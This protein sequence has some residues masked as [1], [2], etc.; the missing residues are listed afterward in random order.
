MAGV[1]TSHHIKFVE[2]KLRSAVEELLFEL[3]RVTIGRQNSLSRILSSGEWQD[4]F[5]LSQRHAIIGVTFAGVRKLQ[6]NGQ[7]IP[8]DLYWQW[9]GLSSH[10]QQCNEVMNAHCVEACNRLQQTGFKTC[11]LKGQ[12]VAQ[13]YGSDLSMLR[14]SGDI[15]LWVDGGIKRAM[16]WAKENYGDVAFEYINAHVPMFNETEVELHWR[17]KYMSNL[18]KNRK[19]QNWIEEHE[20][21]LLNTTIELP[22]GVGSI[23]VPSLA[24]NRYY[25][26]LHCYSH[27]FSEGLGLRQIMDLYFVLAQNKLDNVKDAD[28]RKF[29]LDCLSLRRFTSA[30]MWIM[31]YVFGLER[32]K[33]LCEPDEKEGKYILNEVI[34]N[35]NM[36]Q[37]DHRIIRVSKNARIQSVAASLQHTRHLATHYPSEFLWTPIYIVFHFC[38]KRICVRC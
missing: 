11:I 30:M 6:Q 18:F 29:F 34:L 23:P 9:L 33:M 28:F 20:D 26:L 15:D 27:I 35:G 2:E 36:G 38:W 5:A 19:L 24:L 14:Q 4:L 10:I 12:G 7:G 3:I 8:S 21:E 32:E 1:L 31:G 13:L 17:V 37:H 25:I 22:N 16:A